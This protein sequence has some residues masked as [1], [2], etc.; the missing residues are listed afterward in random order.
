MIPLVIPSLTNLRVLVTRPA[1]QA[2]SLCKQIQRFGGI[3]LAFPVL[4]IKPLEFVLPIETY[5]LLIFVSVNAVAHGLSL[6]KMQ[7]ELNNTSPLIAVIGNATAAAL[8]QL[9]YKPDVVAAAP[10]NSEALL[11]HEALQSPPARILLVRGVGGREVLR[12]TL[13]ARGSVVEVMEV[14]ERV[15]AV[16]DNNA[17]TEILRALR[18][19]LIDVI[20]ITST[21]IVNALMPLFDANDL[22]L[23]QRVAV[24]A[25]SVRIAARL[26]ACG[27]QGECIVSASPDDA[28]MLRALI[29]WHSRARN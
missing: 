4:E 26:S 2:Q 25:G 5:D 8:E 22:E 16:V 10:F 13:L 17:R 9:G 11:K 6:L 7:H 23:L 21:D 24:V 28:A 14:Y 29:R 27:W 1:H 15:T 3:A 12:D 19:G 18:E 20:T